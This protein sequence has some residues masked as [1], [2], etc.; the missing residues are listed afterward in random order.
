MAKAE[1]FDHDWLFQII[2]AR[3][4]K[5]QAKTI[6]RF[7]YFTWAG[8]NKARRVLNRKKQNKIDVLASTFQT[9]KPLFPFSILFHLK[10]WKQ[11]EIKV[12]RLNYSPTYFLICE[13]N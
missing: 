13:K 2:Q 4:L 1:W 10:V 8:I 3:I 11:D 12:A 6:G 7:S 5:I 9:W